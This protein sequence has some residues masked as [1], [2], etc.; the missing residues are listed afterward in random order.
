MLFDFKCFMLRKQ[1][2]S[3]K[4]CTLLIV[5]TLFNYRHKL[6]CLNC[7]HIHWYN[8]LANMFCYSCRT[9]SSKHI[10]ND[11]IIRIKN[12]LNWYFI[13]Y[14]MISDLYIHEIYTKFNIRFSKWWLQPVSGYKNLFKATRKLYK[15]AP[16][17]M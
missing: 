11:C 7:M 2:I 15:F 4:L 12:T 14:S 3:D 8:H 13:N 1:H 10:L 9:H 6:S 16:C 17:I 5:W